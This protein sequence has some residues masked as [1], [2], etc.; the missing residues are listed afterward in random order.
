MSDKRDLI[1]HALNKDV[2]SFRKDFAAG[3][4]ELMA[5]KISFSAP[6]PQPVVEA[7]ESDDEGTK[8]KSKLSDDEKKIAKKAFED[9]AKAASAKKESSEGDD[10]DKGNSDLYI[11]QSSDQILKKAKEIVVNYNKAHENNKLEVRV[12]E[13]DKMT[14]FFVNGDEVGRRQ[15]KNLLKGIGGKLQS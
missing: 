12:F 3:M 7:K 11:L 6:A 15:V 1:N 14:R 4:N 10:D 9:G 5:S 8:K 2:M 13:G